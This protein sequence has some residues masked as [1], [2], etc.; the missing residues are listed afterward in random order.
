MS[1]QM[2]S[3]RVVIEDKEKD[4]VCILQYLYKYK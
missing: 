4:Y 3:L 1:L 2:L